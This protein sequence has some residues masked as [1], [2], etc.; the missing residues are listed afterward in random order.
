MLL[1]KNGNN[2]PFRFFEKKFK[3]F[4]KLLRYNARWKKI[5][6]NRLVR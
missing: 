2:W 5:N 4:I 1:T 3:N 6:N